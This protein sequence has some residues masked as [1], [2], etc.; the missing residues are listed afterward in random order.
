MQDPLD[1]RLLSKT[2]PSISRHVGGGLLMGT[3]GL[4]LV[5]GLSIGAMPYRYRKQ[6]WQLQGGAAG[7]IVGYLVG[8]LHRG[9]GQD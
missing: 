5:I 4:A 6:I 1:Q 2:Q 8:R 3:A 9:I 7:L